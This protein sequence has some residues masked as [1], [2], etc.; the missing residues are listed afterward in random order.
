MRTTGT[1]TQ[2]SFS[3]SDSLDA[4]GN[5]TV[6]YLIIQ[7][8]QIVRELLPYAPYEFVAPAATASASTSGNPITDLQYQP[9]PWGHFSERE[10]QHSR[11]NPDG[12]QGVLASFLRI[13]Q[14]ARRDGR[15]QQSMDNEANP[16]D[17]SGHGG[18]SSNLSQLAGQ[19]SGDDNNSATN[20]ASPS[21]TA[22]ESQSS[23]SRQ[24]STEPRHDHDSPSADMGSDGNSTSDNASAKAIT[25]DTTSSH[26][27]RKRKHAAI[28]RDDDGFDN[29][30]D[31][32]TEDDDD[33]TEDGEG[34]MEDTRGSAEM[35]RDTHRPQ[36][37]IAR[38]HHVSPHRVA[39]GTQSQPFS[40]ES[41]RQKRARRS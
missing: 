29:G 35:P 24:S 21:F 26:G 14:P 9:S 16:G 41:T 22:Q 12:V 32:D 27:R 28:S 18:L 31:K 4:E 19:S 23:E 6:S 33:E 2:P 38:R 13:H 20:S 36:V 11:S 37:V 8:P 10:R 39:E 34:Q 1:P 7:L 5:A 17:R 25:D 40:E 15:Q 30:G 3:I